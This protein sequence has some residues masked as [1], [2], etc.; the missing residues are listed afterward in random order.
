MN[1][2]ILG[3]FLGSG[4]T[5]V[6]LEIVEYVSKSIPDSNKVKVAVIENEIGDISIDGP[7][8]AAHGLNVRNISNGCVC[9]TLSTDLV[10]GAKSIMETINPA[11]LI[12]ETTGLAYPGKV[13]KLIEDFIPYESLR[14]VVIV[15]AERF[16]ELYDILKPLVTGQITGSDRVLL[17]K[18]DLAS[19]TVLENTLV[20]LTQIN[21]A[22]EIIPVSAKTGLDEDVL[23]WIVG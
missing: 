12:V 2:L 5:T 10:T 15:D 9:C 6:L 21:P 1:I 8:I 22:A 3:G 4:K 7:A 20:M 19:D 11:W 16:T 23:R 18:S 14:T 17:N 13:S